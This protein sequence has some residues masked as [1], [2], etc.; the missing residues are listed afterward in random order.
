MGGSKALEEG[1]ALSLDFAK[2]D[3]VAS[4]HCDVVP[5]V[6]QDTRSGNVL[7]CACACAPLRAVPHRLRR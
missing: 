3:K 7:I 1:A 6:V 5:V 4:K 2:L